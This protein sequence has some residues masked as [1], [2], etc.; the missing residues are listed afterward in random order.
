MPGPGPKASI[1]EFSVVL[2]VSRKYLFL[3]ICSGLNDYP[4]GPYADPHPGERVGLGISLCQDYGKG[5][6]RGYKDP[7]SL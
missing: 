6:G 7:E 4:E 2:R 1:Y 3:D 5:W